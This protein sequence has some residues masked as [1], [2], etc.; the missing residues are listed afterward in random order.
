M[1]SR[2]RCSE[3][4]KAMDVS[5]LWTIKVHVEGHCLDLTLLRCVCWTLRKRWCSRY[6]FV[7]GTKFGC[8]RYMLIVDKW[9]DANWFLPKRNNLPIDVIS[10]QEEKK[11]REKNVS[12]GG[13]KI[14]RE[15][16]NEMTCWENK[17]LEITLTTKRWCQWLF[18]L[19]LC[20]RLIASDRENE[21]LPVE[22][23]NY[24]LCW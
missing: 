17:L 13:K 6:L 4:E 20:S 5:Q 18:F 9:L 10:K 22:K 2:T 12:P 24:L 8:E 7:T 23:G 1:R 11:K 16:R 3:I 15:E 14:D 21:K 19:S